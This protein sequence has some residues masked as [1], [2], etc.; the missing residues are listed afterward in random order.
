MRILL[1]D[2]NPFDRE[3]VERLLRRAL[4]EA[5]LTLL[6]TAQELSHALE[7]GEPD[8]VVT[9]YNLQWGD[10][11]EVL[12]EV[13]KRYPYCPVIMFTDSGSEELVVQAMRAGLSDY[14]LKKHLRTLPHV[15]T[16]ALEE[17][18]VRRERDEAQASLAESE[19]RFRTISGLVSDYAYSF[20]LDPQGNST[21]TWVSPSVPK[22]LGFL[23][24]ELADLTSLLALIHPEDRE[25]LASHLEE[26]RQ[27]KSVV[28]LLRMVTRQGETRWVRNFCTPRWDETGTR[29]IGGD[30]AAQD[31][32]DQK[33]AEEALQGQME[34]LALLNQVARAIL[35]RHDLASVFG[36]VPAH[37]ETSLPVDAAWIAQVAGEEL[38]IVGLTR[39]GSTFLSDCLRRGSSLRLCP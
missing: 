33:A 25:K 39:T 21:I 23:P 19:R 13:K 27:G 36:V 10:G 8:V 29:V 3:L 7:A 28:G 11:L 30:G 16:H 15:I 18:R 2:D 20:L 4:P 26:V 9:D 5:D 37:V 31:I 34:R 14:V 22:R 17:A 6:G 32:T 24:E 1:I 38:E 35:E 12:A